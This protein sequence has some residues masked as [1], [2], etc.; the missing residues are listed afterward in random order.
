MTWALI[1]GI[2]LALLALDLLTFSRKPHEVGFAEAAWWS[3]FYIAVAVAFGVWVWWDA[4]SVY[5]T[6][7][8]AAYLVE[9]SLS[10]DNVFVFAIIL[11]QF[12][13]PSIYQQ[14]VLLIGVVLA[15][16]FRAV[17][18]AVGAA[19]LA[20]FAFTFVIF[21]AI[22]IWTGFGLMR[23]WNEDPD[24]SDNFV[25]KFVKRRFP[26]TD[27]YHGTKLFVKEKGVRVV[28]PMFIVMIAIASTDLLFALDSIPATFGITQEPFLV[29]SVNAF[30]LL[31]LRALYFL[32]K[33]LLDRLIYLSLGLSFI[34][35]FI[36]IKLVLLFGY[37][38]FGSVVPKIETS[39]SLIVIAG[40]LIVSIVASLIKSR[41]DPTA[42][43]HAGRVTAPKKD[44]ERTEK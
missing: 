21:G 39:L 31:G 37:E 10:V 36:G 24:P 29:F 41:T 43:A 5:G 7:Y 25:V 4:G 18:I 27:S 12:A 23:H 6:E 19:A 1:I 35:I 33:G 17:F 26:Y 32:I 9:K 40:I 2:I 8:F 34:L 22:L 11:T 42:I 38:T 20:Y 15:L 30:A 44:K 28:T 16:I 13:V 14:R 3:A